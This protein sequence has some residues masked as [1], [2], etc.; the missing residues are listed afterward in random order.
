MPDDPKA[1]RLA[2]FFS[3]LIRSGEAW[4]EEEW[5]K[6]R[7][8]YEGDTKATAPQRFNL[9]RSTLDTATAYQLQID[10]TIRVEP[11]EGLADD[12][13]AQAQAACD[14]ALLKYLW[15]EMGLA[16]ERSRITHDSKVIGLGFGR[17]C[18]DLRRMLPCF[19]H[20]DPE[21]VRVDPNCRG[22]LAEASW[23]AFSEYVSPDM[24]LRERK[25]LD[26]EKLMK[27]ASGAAGPEE[28]PD[29]REGQRDALKEAR[30]NVGKHLRRVRLWRLFLRN[31]AA[32]Y[33]KEPESV[34]D[35]EAGPHLE[36]F[37]DKEGLT[38][39]RRY[40][41]LVE[42]YDGPA[43][44]DEDKW[45][46]ALALDYD[47]WP[48]K[49]LAYNEAF[50]RVAGFSDWRHLNRLEVYLETV[51]GDANA[52][53]A[54]KN[55]GAIGLR[56][57]DTRSEGQLKA[58]L[59]TTGLKIVRDA[60]DA[61]GN[62]KMRVLFDDAGLSE[63]DLA[64][65]KLLHDLHDQMSGVPKIRQAGETDIETAT[66]A[67]ILSEAS[68][69]RV[70]AQ[71][72]LIEEWD[73]VVVEQLLAMAHVN[74]RKLSS[75]EIVLP[76][77]VGYDEQGRPYRVPKQTQA[78]D[79]LTWAEVSNILAQDPSAQL[80]SLG[81]EAMVGPALAE[82]WIDGQPLDVVRRSVRVRVERGSTQRRV[83][84]RKV[85]LALKLYESVLTPLYATRPDLLVKFARRVMEMQELDSDFGDVLPTDQEM[86]VAAQQTALAAA[87]GGPAQPGVVA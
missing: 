45:P 72:R 28:D 29:A 41:E 6:A 3:Q 66:E 30:E 7:E 82:A 55:S 17:C 58:V 83:R 5:D 51:I 64:W 37:R 11:A 67:E 49:R 65:V 10:P 19:R 59:E 20:I 38:E 63:Q 18:M 12:G 46:D 14:E 73:A 61:N 33:D 71:L 70:E 8:A 47:A 27:S 40:V 52:D 79:G 21:D 78:V 57:G 74:L 69:A 2:R 48:L 16:K 81:V 31:A 75:V 76:E 35:E 77:Q 42:G 60:L 23:L 84:E 53:M 34:K 50:H 87:A 36:R 22:N 68:N 26:S 15:D 56:D 25:G 13:A 62:P 39:P 1:L 43:L 80:V 44:V 9:W 4:P 86:Q 85:M 24:L 32:L 54:L